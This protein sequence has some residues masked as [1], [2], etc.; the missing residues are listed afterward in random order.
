MLQ[1]ISR[2]VLVRACTERCLALFFSPPLLH[3]SFAQTATDTRR[4]R[5]RR[6]APPA[7]DGVK[8]TDELHA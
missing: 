7:C 4:L 8:M 6:P 3:S 1:K 2:A 5:P